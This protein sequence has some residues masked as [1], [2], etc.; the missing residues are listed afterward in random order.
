VLRISHF[1]R[2]TYGAVVNLDAIAY[3][4]VDWERDADDKP[5]CAGGRVQL[6]GSP[7]VIELDAFDAHVLSDELDHLD[8]Q[9]LS[10]GSLAINL[11][12]MTAYDISDWDWGFDDAGNETG[13]A[14]P[15][16]KVYVANR[17]EPFHLTGQD[18][19]DFWEFVLHIERNWSTELATRRWQRERRMAER[20]RERDPLRFI[21]QLI[22]RTREE[23]NLAIE[24]VAGAIGMNSDQIERIETGEDASPAAWDIIRI[25]AYLGIAGSQLYRT[26]DPPRER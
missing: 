19:E 7:D 23:R 1:V 13:S 10:I 16:V 4:K 21:R 17:A 15:D 6:I 11:R 18:A 12:H 8:D 3:L 24:D 9:L 2:L 20:Q 22:R 5:S 25:T 14:R 26:L